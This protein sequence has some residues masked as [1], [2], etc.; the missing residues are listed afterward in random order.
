VT[1]AY[2]FIFV[3]AASSAPDAEKADIYALVASYIVRRLLCGLTAKNYNKVFPQIATKLRT[4]CVTLE[5]A[6]AAFRALTGDSQRFP[7]DA[8]F[9]NAILTRP[10]YTVISQRRLQ[11]VLAEL[12]R[13]SRTP[14]HEN[15]TVPESLTIEHVLPNEWREHWPLADGSKAV[16]DLVTG[17]TES[18][19]KTIADR[20]ALKHTLGNLTLLTG[21]LN[22]SISN[23]PFSHKR[24]Q[25]RSQ[26]LLRLNQEIAELPK[27]DEECIRARA[28]TLATR[29]IA[30]W[31]GVNEFNRASPAPV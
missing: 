28:S 9:T 12:E 5:A 19:L 26:S 7:E 17:M 21:A 27:W 29:A 11:Y 18:Q 14:F 20:E 8:E 3:V 24:E 6:R 16:A 10:Q 1:T 13:A 2:P 4:S 30:I 25:L 22:P 31:P 23:L 15:T